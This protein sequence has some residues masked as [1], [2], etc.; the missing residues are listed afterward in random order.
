MSLQNLYTELLVD[1]T[2][3]L[4]GDIQ[5]RIA[6]H[7]L[8]DGDTDLLLGLLGRSELDADVDRRIGESTELPVLITWMLRPG[9]DPE[10]VAGRVAREK[11][12]TVLAVLA[13]TPGLPRSV[14]ENLADHH[15]EKVLKAL[16]T[17]TA[18]DTE[19]RRRAVRGLVS[20]PPRAAYADTCSSA[21]RDLVNGSGAA[22]ILWDEVGE[23]ATAL[24][25]L[26]ALAVHGTPT[27]SHLTRW[28]ENLETIHDYDDG[29]WREL[30]PVLVTTMRERS[31][32][33]HQHERLL[34][35][36]DAILDRET[37]PGAA[38]VG[39]LTRVRQL[40]KGYDIEAEERIRR[41]AAETDPGE[42]DRLLRELQRSCRNAQRQ[43]LIALA[44]A[45]PAVRA[46]TLL[47]LRHDFT[48]SDVG[49]LAERLETGRRTDLLDAWLD[50]SEHAAHVPAFV[51]Y[52]TEPQDFLSAHLARRTADRRT[53]PTWA[54][55]TRELHENPALGVDHLPW[56]VL[57]TSASSVPGLTETI[58]AALVDAL[59]NDDERWRTFEVIGGDFDGT[60]G[61]LLLVV[62]DLTA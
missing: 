62:N 19:I 2:S 34:C 11:R 51:S 52:L 17:G 35:A 28:A 9:R 38:W 61:E 59:E 8:R 4:T 50:D 15:S 7:A 39:E 24:P 37:G 22:R 45:H 26:V 58:T 33:R 13:D 30:T 25:H 3:I 21:L 18:C 5:H 14:Y 56:R 31:L 36:I 53:W 12:V 40:V 43:R 10:T 20:R 29:R 57:A 32:T 48:I 44:A 42:A 55:D 23:H 27:S 6:S 54:L 60:L 41:F 49:R 47:E 1:R 16:V 46:E